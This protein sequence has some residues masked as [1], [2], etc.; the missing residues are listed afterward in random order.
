MLHIS[1]PF[2]PRHN[3]EEKRRLMLDRIVRFECEE[4]PGPSE[5]HSWYVW[6]RRHHEPPTISYEGGRDDPP[7]QA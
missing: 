3:N 6:N 5:N 2:E 1:S 4:A 7:P